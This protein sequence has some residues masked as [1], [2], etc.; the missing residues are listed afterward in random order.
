M[1][2]GQ[3]SVPDVLLLVESGAAPYQQAARGFEGRYGGAGLTR[4]QLDAD[5]RAREARLAD[6]AVTRPRLLV[7]VGGEAARAARRRWPDT[8]LVYCLAVNSGPTLL[9]GAQTGGVGMSVAPAHQ[10]EV[11][12][13]LVPGARR[14]GTVYDPARSADLIRQ[15]QPHLPAGGRLAQR[16]AGSPREAAVA[17]REL[18]P[19]V[20]AFWMLLDPVVANPANFRVL[21]DLSLRHRVP[22]LAPAAPFVEAGALVSVGPDY[23][24]AGRRAAEIAEQV[25]RG[26]RPG[27]FVEPAPA[28]VVTINGR[29]ARRFGLPIPR[30]LPAHILSPEGAP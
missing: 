20:D 12:K 14:I 26:A 9:Q 8:P 6:F 19:Q 13:R 2:R 28:Y 30:D 16:T 24:Q 23:G 17:I 18:I 29:V 7:V 3:T 22:L 4:V 5:V 1:A 25:L 11:L 21:V 10:F 27:D 15:A